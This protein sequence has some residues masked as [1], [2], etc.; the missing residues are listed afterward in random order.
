M[1]LGADAF[2]IGCRREAAMKKVSMQGILCRVD[3]S[4]FSA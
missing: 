1:T 4:D 2:I 3:F